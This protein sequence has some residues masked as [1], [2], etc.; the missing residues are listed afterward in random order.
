[1]KNEIYI[2]FQPCGGET[3]TLKRQ[4]IKNCKTSY[5]YLISLFF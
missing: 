1:M 2:S 5:W 3:D 4:Q